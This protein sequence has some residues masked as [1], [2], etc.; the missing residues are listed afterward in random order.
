LKACKLKLQRFGLR[1]RLLAKLWHLLQSKFRTLQRKT[2]AQATAEI[3]KSLKHQNVV[4]PQPLTA[5]P[6]TST[7]SGSATPAEVPKTYRDTNFDP[8]LLRV[9]KVKSVLASGN[10]LRGDL[11]L[12][13]GGV[14][15]MC[16]VDGNVAQI[17]DSLVI[18][19]KEAVIKGN[20]KAQ[21][22]LVLGRVEGG[23]HAE[24][25][26][27]GAS[28]EVRGRI[29][30]RRSFGVITGAKVLAQIH[31]L[32]VPVFGNERPANH[33]T[34]NQKPTEQTKVVPFPASPQSDGVDAQRRHIS[35]K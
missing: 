19:D 25:I 22:L 24:R 13:N 12:K 23:I 18:V 4:E 2:A 31:E 21:Y 34:P 5:A 10:L 28:A 6:T 26:V 11:I 32:D 15:L 7:S 8:V 16:E 33:A 29:I 14:R 27:I 17:N 20:I 30:Y 3:S 35:Q 1:I 9:G